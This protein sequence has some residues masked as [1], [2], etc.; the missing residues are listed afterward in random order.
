MLLGISLQNTNRIRKV[1]LP[2]ETIVDL[3]QAYLGLGGYSGYHPVILAL[4][5]TEAPKMECLDATVTALVRIEKQ[6]N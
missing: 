6:L 4:T 3:D 1:T 2:R 5:D